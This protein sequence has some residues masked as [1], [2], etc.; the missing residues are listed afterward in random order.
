MMRKNIA[1]AEMKSHFSEYVSKSAYQHERFIITKR[2]KPVAALVTIDD[3]QELEQLEAR[4][5]LASVAKRWKGF[6]EIARELDDLKNIRQDTKGDR[7]V[8][9]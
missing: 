5:G 6:D 4:R 7:N 9:F 2:D 8:S 3:L 1:L